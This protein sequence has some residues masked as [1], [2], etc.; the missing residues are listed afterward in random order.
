MTAI[1]LID[2][3]GLL[4]GPVDLPVIPGIGLQMPGNAIVLEN[5][6][7][8]AAEDHFW[9][10]VDGQPKQL[11]D[12][13]GTAYRTDTGE[14]VQ[15]DQLGP[16][17][18]GLTILPRPSPDHRWIAESWQIDPE[19]QA[20]NREELV[21]SLCNQVDTAADAARMAV[22]GDPLR[23]VEYERAAAEAEQFRAA[24]YPVDAVP[25]AVA[26]WAINGRTAQQ[27]ADSILAEAEI[28][29]EALYQLR[30]TR[31]AAKEQ[32]RT[33]MAT[34]DIA[35]AQQTASDTVAAIQASVA[36]IGNASA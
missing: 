6:L 4:G 36:G 1:Y 7:P 11:A 27:A 21:V 28:F 8:A 12:S 19:L 31:L 10:W 35:I 30:E 17:P 16:L 20:A 15:H 25:R 2:N 26:A 13:R 34:G 29:N 24:G 3:D 18:A 14:A 33:L 5:E 23:A 22:A 9:V 32:I